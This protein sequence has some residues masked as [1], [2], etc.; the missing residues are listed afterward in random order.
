MGSLR[1]VCWELLCVA[2][3]FTGPVARYI[4]GDAH[5]MAILWGVFATSC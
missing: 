2:C 4:F 3:T 1:G 5:T